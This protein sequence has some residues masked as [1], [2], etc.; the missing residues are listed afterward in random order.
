MIVLNLVF[1]FSI[2]GISVGGHLGGLAG[3]I[4]A[5]LALAQ[6]RYGRGWRPM[7]G[8]ALAVLVGVAS[9]AVAYVRVE[10]YTF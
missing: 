3:G 5:T 9:L 6:L 8:P 7:L 1:T 10:S 2:P 4:A